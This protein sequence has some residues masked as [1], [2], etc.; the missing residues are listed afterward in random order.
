MFE[1]LLQHSQRLVA[2]VLQVIDDQ[3]HVLGQVISRVSEVEAHFLTQEGEAGDE[4]AEVGAG[5]GVFHVGSEDGYGHRRR[6]VA[7]DLGREEEGSGGLG[8]DMYT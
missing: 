4:V 2:P 3:G 7:G 1:Q 6:P 5:D 8:R